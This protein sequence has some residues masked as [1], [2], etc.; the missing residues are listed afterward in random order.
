MFKLNPYT[1]GKSSLEEFPY[2]ELKANYPPPASKAEVGKFTHNLPII[3]GPLADN[4]S[5]ESISALAHDRIM[6]HESVP[7]VSDLSDVRSESSK[8][9]EEENESLIGRWDHLSCHKRIFQL[10]SLVDRYHITQAE[11]STLQPAPMQFVGA[12]ARILRSGLTFVS[13]AIKSARPAVKTVFTKAKDAILEEVKHQAVKGGAKLAKK[14][15]SGT[16]NAFERSKT[17][18]K[19]QRYVKKANKAKK[20]QSRPQ[21]GPKPGM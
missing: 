6:A 8:E 9:A 17:N 18:R 15:F 5:T 4:L 10:Q 13:S 2:S 16:Q 3:A 21:T 19:T 7:S 11:I 20:T 12:I 1:L 14:A